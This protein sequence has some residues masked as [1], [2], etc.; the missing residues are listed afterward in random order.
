[1]PITS[2]LDHLSIW[3]LVGCI[4]AG[5][6]IS[7]EAGYRF[8]KF[9]CA[10]GEPESGGPLGAI[11]AS[12]LGL[13]AFMLTFTFGFAASRFEE[14][15]QMVVEEANAIGTAYLRAGLLPVQQKVEVRSLLREY[16]DSRLELVRTGDAAL[17]L[18]RADEL[19]RLLWSE[20]EAAGKLA[21][22]SVSVGLFID[23][24]NTTIDVHSKR[25]LI[26]L[27]SRLPI[28]LWV[29]LFLLTIFSMAGVGY[30]E[31]LAKSRRS[32]ATVVMV[33]SFLIVTMLIIDLDRP[34]EGMITVSQESIVNLRN[35]F[36]QLDPS[37]GNPSPAVKN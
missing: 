24:I 11:V 1:M 20:A 37:L 22:E 32:P 28:I 35:S 36:D 21:P 17:A 31:A 4:A 34:R 14:R 8:G 30:Q 3:L 10:H 26:G 27:R 16:V 33:F 6:F 13:L 18:R 25:V 15:R 23:A 9:R 19:H 5:I 2:P 12:T 7:I 29:A